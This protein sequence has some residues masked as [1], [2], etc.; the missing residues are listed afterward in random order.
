MQKYG[1]A[2]QLGTAGGMWNL[3]YAQWVASN[4]LLRG[5]TASGGSSTGVFAL[6]LN[7]AAANEY[8]TIGFRCAL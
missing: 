6:A 5:G 4:I 1:S 8:R 2:T 3:Y 7:D